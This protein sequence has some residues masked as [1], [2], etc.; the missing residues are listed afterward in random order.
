MRVYV[1]SSARLICVY[2]YTYSNIEIRVKFACSF[3]IQV[4]D[5]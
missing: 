2:Q 4:F 5:V 3:A 1:S